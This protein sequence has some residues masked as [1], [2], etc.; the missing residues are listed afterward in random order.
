[1]VSEVDKFLW[2]YQPRQL[3]TKFQRFEDPLC[4]HYQGI[5]CCK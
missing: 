3:G 4:F 1:M 2:G 5:A